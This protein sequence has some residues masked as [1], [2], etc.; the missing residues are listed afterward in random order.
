MPQTLHKAL[1]LDRDGVINVDVGFAHRPEQ[2]RFMDGIFELCRAAK[3]KEY[4]IIVATNQSGIGRGYFSEDDFLSVMDWIKAQ[5]AIQDILID[6]V[7]FCPHHPQEGKGPYRQDCQDRK[8]NPGMFLQAQREHRIDMARSL[9][10]GDHERDL[11]AG[12]NAGV[13][14][15]LIL[16]RTAPIGQPIL[17]LHEAVILL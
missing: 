14:R 10:I 2:I 3:A 15:L 1:F 16:G 4:L 7:Y 11:Q 12:K 9:L 8:P 13:G 6:A 5:F 17:S